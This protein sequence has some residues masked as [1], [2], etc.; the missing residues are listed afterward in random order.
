[1]RRRGCGAPRVPIA[2]SRRASTLRPCPASR[3]TRL[4][5]GRSC[6]TSGSGALTRLDVCDAHPELMRAAQ[7]IGVEIDDQCP[8]CGESNLRLVSYVYGEKLE[9]G[10]RPGD[11]RPR[12]SSLKLGASVRRV[13]L[14]RR[15]GLPRL[16]VEPLCAA[17]APRPPARQL[18]LTSPP[19]Q[20]PRVGHALELVGAPVFECADLI[21]T[22]RS[23]TVRMRRISPRL[24]R[25]ARRRAPMR[26][27]DPAGR[28]AAAGARPPR[29]AA[30]R[31]SAGP[32]ARRVSL[33]SCALHCR[34]TVDQRVRYAVAGLLHHPPA[35]APRRTA[36]TR[37]VVAVQQ[38]G[39]RS[40]SPMPEPR[41]ASSRRCR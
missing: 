28:R 6:A 9:A 17:V 40:R 30:R 35:E 3:T 8:V 15:R 23:R 29:C 21:R 16:P 2:G 25:R 24:R 19:Q 32:W 11:Q 5:D 4:L 18:T 7:N 12:R 34:A 36:G 39:C 33:S 37:C 31:G 41:S 27:G 1:M 14:L 20:L 13:R 22:T 10:Q 26:T 38:L